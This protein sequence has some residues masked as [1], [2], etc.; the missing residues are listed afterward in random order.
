M[1]D[2]SLDDLMGLYR[3]GARERTSPHVDGLVL[4]E[5]ER[6]ARRRRVSR[7][8][9]RLLTATAAAAVLS[10]AFHAMGARPMA[11]VAAA[12]V[13]TEVNDDATRAYLQRMDVMPGSSGTQQYLMVETS[14]TYGRL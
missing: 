3:Q 6:A 1:N 5:A 7:W 12:P 13:S 11:P 8:S 10:L 4:A 14:P 2:E 9:M